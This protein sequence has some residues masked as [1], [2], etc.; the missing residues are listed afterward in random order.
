[1]RPWIRAPALLTAAQPCAHAFAQVGHLELLCPGIELVAA[2]LLQDE[3]W[4][5]ACAGCKFV[6][7]IASPFPIGMSHAVAHPTRAA[8]TRRTRTPHAQW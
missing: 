2:D 8:L 6:M 7:H 1:M 3:G 5:A 4:E